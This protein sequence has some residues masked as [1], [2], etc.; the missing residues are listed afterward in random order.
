MNKGGKTGT[1]FKGSKVQ[2]KNVTPDPR[3]GRFVYLV[4]DVL[5]LDK[6]L[7]PWRM[8]TSARSIRERDLVFL[9]SLD[10]IFRP[11]QGFG[12]F[13]QVVEHMEDLANMLEHPVFV[14]YD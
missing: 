5:I 6:N 14:Y 7:N 9:P 12:I 3:V 10:D 8:I 4:E 2:G 13:F 1:K 11:G